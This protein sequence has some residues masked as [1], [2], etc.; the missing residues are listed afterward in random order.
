MLGQCRSRGAGSRSGG[1]VGSQR[2]RWPCPAQP[3]RRQGERRRAAAATCCRG[4][5]S[6]GPGAAPPPVA[7]SLKLV[8]A[9]ALIDVSTR[10][11]LLA[12]R[13]RGKHLAGMW[14]LPGGKLEVGE[15]PEEALRRELREELGVELLGELQPLAFASHP[16]DDGSHLLMPLWACHSWRGDPTPREGQQLAWVSASEL[17]QYSMP[18]ADEPLLPAVRAALHRCNE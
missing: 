3:Q 6:S 18:P 16:L 15:A 7:V 8:V 12:K 13:P 11:V 9:A 14:E 1:R 2:A 17:G 4:G 10:K 5:G